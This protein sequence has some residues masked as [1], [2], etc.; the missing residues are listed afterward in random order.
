VSDMEREIRDMLKSKS[1]RAPVM[2]EPPK[3]VLRRARTRKVTNSIG[4]AAI[5]AILAVGGF[6][7]VRSLTA[8][9]KVTPDTSGPVPWAPLDA[10]GP[11]SELPCRAGDLNFSADAGT[12]SSLLFSAKR[13][14]IRCTLL[15]NFSL[16]LSDANGK[17]LNVRVVIADTV[18]GI[19]IDSTRRSQGVLF[20][21]S[22]GCPPTTAPI[23]FSVTFPEGGGTLSAL[24]PK[25][26]DITCQGNRSPT[27]LTM[28]AGGIR[29]NEAFGSQSGLESALSGVPTSAAAG[30]TLRYSVVLR[31]PTSL[32]IALDP[33]P[34]YEETL[35]LGSSYRTGFRWLLNCAAAPEV[36][37]PGE[38]VRF[39]ME[40]GV[41]EGETGSARLEWALPEISVP[42]L[43]ANITIT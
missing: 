18:P 27:T 36:I 19:V 43:T 2:E 12:G 42:L 21:W 15:P 22:N 37:R 30:D 17:A 5:V 41:P 35:T 10:P 6:A 34:A 39:L 29:E 26:G 31:N 28:V 9:Q 32:P 38:S 40:F 1:S 8:A 33:C 16:K 4:L 14:G 7:G 11:G 23:L 3:P 25:V 13:A 24:A 20:D